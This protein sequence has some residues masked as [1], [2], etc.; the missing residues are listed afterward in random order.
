MSFFMALMALKANQHDIHVDPLFE[1]VQYN[2]FVSFYLFAEKFLELHNPFQQPMDWR[3]S[4]AAS[5]FHRDVS[6]VH[7]C[8][9]MVGLLL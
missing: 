8:T 5:S 3:L 7:T 6:F 1:K 2:Y 9:T 4:S